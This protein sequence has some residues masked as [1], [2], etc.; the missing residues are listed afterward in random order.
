MNNK[1]KQG[2]TSFEV[3]I[4]IMVTILAIAGFCDVGILVQKMDSVNMSVGYVSRV[5]SRQGG[6]SPVK[7]K[8][9]SGE[10]VTSAQLYSDVTDM[11]DSSGLNEEKWKIQINGNDFSPTMN[12]GP[13]DYGKTLNVSLVSEYKW[14]FVGNFVPG[15][16]KTNVE[17]KAKG[18]STFKVRNGGFTQSDTVK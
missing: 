10:Y 2:I 9:F 14:A 11:M 1:I 5:I 6:V 4:G 8:N 18:M 15:E 7:I 12:Y 17:S 3:V 13:L 16:I